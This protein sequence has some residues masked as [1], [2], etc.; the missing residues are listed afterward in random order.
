[1][2]N[3]ANSVNLRVLTDS[4]KRFLPNSQAVSLV[5]ILS[6]CFL[7]IL[8][9]TK[10]G[11]VVLHLRVNLVLVELLLISSHKFPF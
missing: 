11:L 10:L 3:Q 4:F 1:M 2:T 7:L 8:Q 6:I 5:M 9:L